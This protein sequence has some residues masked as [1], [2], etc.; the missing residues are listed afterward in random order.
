M[1]SECGTLSK[2]LV[3]KWQKKLIR[4]L[5]LLAAFDCLSEQKDLIGA[6][7]DSNF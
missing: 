3:L 4:M 2:H 5:L 7:M 1:L 6:E